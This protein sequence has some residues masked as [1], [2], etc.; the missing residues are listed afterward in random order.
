MNFDERTPCF[1]KIPDEKRRLGGVFPLQGRTINHT[2]SPLTGSRLSHKLFLLPSVLDDAVSGATS[3]LPT[4][5]KA[6]ILLTTWM[7]YHIKR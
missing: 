1:T 5:Y 2:G 4:R 3:P 7:I 6:D